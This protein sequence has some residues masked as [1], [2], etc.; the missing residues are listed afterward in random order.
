MAKSKE[1]WLYAYGAAVRKRAKQQPDWQH[2]PAG[3]MYYSMGLAPTVAASRFL[4]G[5]KWGKRRRTTHK[6]TR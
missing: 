4:R 6:R 1:S 2:W 3:H 5:T